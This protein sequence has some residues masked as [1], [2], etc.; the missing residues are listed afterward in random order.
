MFL[1]RGDMFAI[2]GDMKIKDLNFK[3][4]ILCAATVVMTH[5]H[6]SGCV[7]DINELT[8][9]LDENFDGSLFIEI[10][11]DDGKVR[12]YVSQVRGDEIEIHQGGYNV[13]T[14]NKF[15]ECISPKMFEK[16]VDKSV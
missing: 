10:W 9:E 5:L 6:S 4:E 16:G 8:C 13:M 14:I 3:I 1:T 2:I 11:S 15:M 12:V 7:N